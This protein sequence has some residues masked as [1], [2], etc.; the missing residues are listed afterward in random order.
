[1]ILHG[2]YRSSASYRVRI[3]LNLKGLPVSHVSHHLR[4]GEQRAADYLPLNPQGLVPTLVADDGRALTQSLAIVEWLDET[5]PQP[6]LL[7]ADP[8][9]RA[10]V[11]AFAQAIACDIHPLQNLR[12]LTK[13]KAM[14]GSDDDSQAWARFVNEDGL[15]ACEAML[16]NEP[17][18]FCFGA[19]PTLADICL[20]PQLVNARRFNADVARFPRLLAIEVAANALPAFADAAPAKQPDAE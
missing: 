10:R 4:K 8:W 15:A 14:T 16:A 3:A 13:V 19:R 7:P 9:E 2:Y 11:R 5:Y 17:G 6:P 20:V 18:P 1:M 12:I